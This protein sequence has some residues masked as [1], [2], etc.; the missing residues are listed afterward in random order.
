[1][2]SLVTVFLWQYSCDSILVTV[3]L[4]QYSCDSILVTLS[5]HLWSDFT[6]PRPVTCGVPQGSVLGPILFPLY[7]ADIGKLIIS[8]SLQHHCYADDTQLYG[9]CRPDDRPALKA[10]ILRCIGA[11]AEWMASNRLKLNRVKAEFMWCCTL[12]RLCHVDYFVF[13][14]K[15]S[16]FNINI[17]S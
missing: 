14:L 2:G 16:I 4:C 11:I 6:S 7:T 9:A 15:D 3:F 8:F 1:M 12:W 5:V 17:G 13:N 10:R